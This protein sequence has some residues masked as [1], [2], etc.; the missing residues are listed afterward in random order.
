[1][2]VLVREQARAVMLFTPKAD[3]LVTTQGDSVAGRILTLAQVPAVKFPD[4]GG[5]VL[6]NSTFQEAFL[7]S[8]TEFAPPPTD[9]VS[10]SE[11][12]QSGV[13]Q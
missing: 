4:A 13:V 11:S 3:R 9:F 5:P 2:V 7:K 8:H 12:I 6:I 10:L 1:M